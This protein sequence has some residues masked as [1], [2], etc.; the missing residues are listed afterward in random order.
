[1]TLG[2]RQSGKHHSDRNKETNGISS[3]T[4]RKRPRAKRKEIRD[5]VQDIGWSRVVEETGDKR[6]H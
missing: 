5:K 1:M 4:V 3:I 6:R 2:G